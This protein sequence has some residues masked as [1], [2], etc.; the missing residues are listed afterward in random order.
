MILIYLLL[1][2]LG[3]GPTPQH[4]GLLQHLPTP[5]LE[6]VSQQPWQ[7]NAVIPVLG[8]KRNMQRNMSQIE[9]P[10][11]P[12]A[13]LSSTDLARLLMQYC[14]DRIREERSFTKELIDDKC[15]T[16][17]T[18]VIKGL[19]EGLAT[20]TKTMNEQSEKLETLEL[21]QSYLVQLLYQQ[22]SDQTSVTYSSRCSVCLKN[23][24]ASPSFHDRGNANHFHCNSCYTVFQSV[25]GLYLHSCTPHVITSPLRCRNCNETF[26]NE[27]QLKEHVDRMHTSQ[28]SIPCESCNEVFSTMDRLR[29]HRTSGHACEISFRDTGFPTIH[30]NGVP[31]IPQPPPEPEPE[32]N[33]AYV[34]RDIPH[35]VCEFCGF[36]TSSNNHLRDH[37]TNCHDKKETELHCNLCMETF[38]DMRNLNIHLKEQHEPYSVQ[39]EENHPDCHPLD[40]S[41][42]LQT[43]GTDDAIESSSLSTNTLNPG[44]ITYNYSLNSQN[45]TRRLVTGAMREPLSITLNDFKSINN[46][47]YAFNVNVECNSGVSLAAIKP[48][49]QQVTT[50]WTATVGEWIIGCTK[51]SPRYDNTHHRLLCTQLALTVTPRDEQSAGCSS[52]HK[53]TVH[54]Y[55]TKDK[56]QVQ[57]SSIISPGTSCPVWLVKYLIEPIAAKHIANNQQ[58]I[59]QINSDIIT[60]VSRTAWTC[61]SCHQNIEQTAAKVRDQPLTCTKCEKQFH[62]KCTDRSSSKGGSWNKDPWLCSLCSLSVARTPEVHVSISSPP[63]SET[64]PSNHCLQSQPEPA[65]LPCESLGPLSIQGDLQ[66]HVRS[67]SFGELSAPTTDPQGSVPPACQTLQTSIPTQT[68]FPNNSIRQRKSNVATLEPEI[69]FQKAT[70]DACRSTIAQQESELKR[71]NECLDLRNKKIMQLESQVGVARSFIASRE[72][73]HENTMPLPHSDQLTNHTTSLSHLLSKLTIVVDNLTPRTPS[74]NVYNSSCHGSKATMKEASCQTSC[75]NLAVIDTTN[76]NTIE[77]VITTNDDAE[78]ILICTVCNISL[79]SNRDLDSHMETAHGCN[80][81]CDFCDQNFTCEDKLKKHKN[82]KH[83]AA[84]LQCPSCM[85]R[86]QTKEDLHAHVNDSHNSTLSLTT[87]PSTVSTL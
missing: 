74:V 49:L 45:Q 40:I 8:P 84:Y 65:R 20:I 82:E 12:K 6:L 79:E 39:L 14:S 75:D 38:N 85:L 56:I 28:A 55:H 77:S 1:Y 48:V 5:A 53:L 26:A 87:V 19:G 44:T 59:D 31:I 66:D 24:K 64:Q 76:T 81:V 47:R 73:P 23:P 83:P 34:Y 27:T 86:F 32:T 30:G 68:R 11:D 13:P 69:E 10:I 67:L 2:I 58:T 41:D 71:L 51:V 17:I 36:I 62:K 29:E 61:N 9:T 33:H 16:V 7:H 78:A 72:V 43:D 21:K 50:D 60:S 18:G 54:F 52:P 57:G 3:H 4:H 46:I 22:M 63:D 37:I 80:K 42:I 15:R 70:I 35:F 25:K